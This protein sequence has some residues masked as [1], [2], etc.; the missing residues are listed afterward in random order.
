MRTI[1]ANK[2]WITLLSLT[3]LVIATFVSSYPAMGMS[4]GDIDPLSPCG[5][6]HQPH[7]LITCT[8]ENPRKLTCRI[9]SNAQIQSQTPH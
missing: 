3:A 9:N 7:R 5:M 1:I 8:T 4:N 6:T 2:T